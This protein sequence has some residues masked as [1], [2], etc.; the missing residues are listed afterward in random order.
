MEN[1]NEYWIGRWKRG[2]TGWHQTEVEQDL[3]KNFKNVTPTSVLV[4]LCGKTLDMVWLAN[5][6]HEVIGVEL[7]EDACIAFFKENNLVFT[8][9]T[10]ASFKVFSSGKI[11]I[12]CGDFFN[13]TPKNLGKIGGVYDRAALIALPIDLRLKYVAHMKELLKNCSDQNNISFL[14]IILERVP[15]DLKGPPFSVQPEEVKQYYQD[16]FKISQ[17]SRTEEESP[18]S[19]FKIYQ[20]VFMLNWK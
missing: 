1:Q 20:S 3:V 6:G 18:S 10:E 19:D 7:F 4:P 16:S 2:E 5:Q 15:H 11:K 17:L 9:S 12:Y 8:Q 14:Q 13:F